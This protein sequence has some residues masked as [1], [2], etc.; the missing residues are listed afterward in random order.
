MK[1]STSMPNPK[2]TNQ[3]EGVIVFY[4]GKVLI[5]DDEL[6]DE[7]VIITQGQALVKLFGYQ[8][9]QGKAYY[10]MENEPT[11]TTPQGAQSAE[12]NKKNY[13]MTV[14]CPRISER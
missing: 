4:V 9:K 3:K 1:A 12:P 7:E 6:T 5:A 10:K 2:S 14:N 11:K 13:T 8:S